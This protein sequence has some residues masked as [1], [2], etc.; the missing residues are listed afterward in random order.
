M[1][2]VGTSPLASTGL[3]MGPFSEGP[4]S[5]PPDLRFVLAAN[6]AVWFMS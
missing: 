5:E 2:G 3:L 1:S 4:L 6:I